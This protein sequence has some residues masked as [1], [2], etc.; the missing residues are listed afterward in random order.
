MNAP[1]RHPQSRLKALRT[2]RSQSGSLKD[3]AGRIM[4]DKKL[5]AVGK[6][7]KACSA[8]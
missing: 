1:D 2:R 4:D 8:N 6:V 5:Q 7:D 3:T